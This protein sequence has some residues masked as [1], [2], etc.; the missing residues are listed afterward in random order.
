MKCKNST[1]NKDALPDKWY[2]GRDCAPY[3]HYQGEGYSGSGKKIKRSFLKEPGEVCVQSSDVEK[4]HALEVTTKSSR[5]IKDYLKKLN[6]DADACGAQKKEVQTIS[7][8]PFINIDK[9]S[10]DCMRLI[11]ES[12]QQ[13]HGFMKHPDCLPRM[14]C[15]T[16]SE[17]HKLLRLKLDLIH[18]ASKAK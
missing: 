13:L 11:D 16:A 12:V 7:N 17:I 4:P 6:R 8:L 18:E 14:A 15:K 2:C 9:A 1:C 10:S 5:E 3:G